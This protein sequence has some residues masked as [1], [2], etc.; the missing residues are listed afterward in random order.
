MFLKQ[1]RHEMDNF[2]CKKN[3]CIFF[4][5]RTFRTEVFSYFKTYILA[6]K[7]NISV[8][9]ASLFYVLPNLGPK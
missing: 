6:D 2:E 4:Y 1:E 9:N 3:F 7:G 8:M 5:F